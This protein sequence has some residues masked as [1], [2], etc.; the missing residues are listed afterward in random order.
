MTRIVAAIETKITPTPPATSQSGIGSPRSRLRDATPG[1]PTG[2]IGPI[3][4][5]KLATLVSDERE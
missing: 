3:L 2:L 1:S 5:I 4:L